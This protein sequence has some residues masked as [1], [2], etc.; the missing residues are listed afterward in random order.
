MA[1][2]C[3]SNGKKKIKDSNNAS[4]KLDK[5][6]TSPSAVDTVV[7]FI[8]SLFERNGYDIS[9]YSFLEP[10]AGGGELHVQLHPRTKCLQH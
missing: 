2:E 6:Y 8:D 10:C 7:D 4:K 3:S 1:V 9:G 5:F